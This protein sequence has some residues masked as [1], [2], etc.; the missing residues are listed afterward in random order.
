MMSFP[1]VQ[2]VSRQV[3]FGNSGKYLD[4]TLLHN[5]T[6][7]SFKLVFFFFF[8]NGAGWVVDIYYFSVMIVLSVCGINLFRDVWNST[9]KIYMGLV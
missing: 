6:L 7:G 3:E 8:F 1:E 5:L 4:G 9:D 2:I